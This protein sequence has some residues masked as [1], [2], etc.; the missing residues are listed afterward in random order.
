MQGIELIC[1]PESLVRYATKSFEPLHT[2]IA[3]L[4]MQVQ[5]LRQ[6]RD[7][8]LPR[9]LYGQIEVSSDYETGAS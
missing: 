2:E 3:T 5:K 8:L 4:S 7:L 1:P 9:L 6:T